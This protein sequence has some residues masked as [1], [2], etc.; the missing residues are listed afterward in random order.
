MGPWHNLPLLR[1]TLGIAWLALGIFSQAWADQLQGRV[2]KVADGDTVTVLDGQRQQHVIRLGGIDAPEKTQ[3]YGQKSKAHL[4]QA[5]FD[6][7][8][9]V[10]FDKRDRYGRIVGKILIGEK[11]INLQQVQAGWAWHYK[12]YQREQ[13]PE[14]RVIYEEAERQARQTHGGLWQGQGPTRPEPPWEYRARL[15]S[16]RQTVQTSTPQ[17]ASSAQ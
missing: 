3:P 17:L 2:V 11:D 1:P 12:Q 5:V 9:T 6:Q 13:R 4:S 7:A 14:D 15:K 10:E 16:E 8:V